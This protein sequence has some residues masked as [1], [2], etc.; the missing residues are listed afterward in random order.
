MHR[1]YWIALSIILVYIGIGLPYAYDEIMNLDF[2][3]Y[4]DCKGGCKFGTSCI[5]YPDYPEVS[6]CGISPLFK[7]VYKYVTTPILGPDYGDDVYERH[8][9]YMLYSYGLIIAGIGLF[10][11]KVWRK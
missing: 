7:P 9:T 6:Y 2:G 4:P 8:N 11:F 3:S 1:N 5:I 10:Y